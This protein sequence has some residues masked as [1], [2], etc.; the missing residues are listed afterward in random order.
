MADT[1]PKCGAKVRYG[2]AGTRTHRADSADCLRNQLATE[3]RRLTEAYQVID[4]FRNQ[5]AQAQAIIG[6]LHP[7]DRG[8]ITRETVL[9]Y[10]DKLRALEEADPMSGAVATSVLWRTV[11]DF[12]DAREAAEAAQKAKPCPTPTPTTPA[13]TDPSPTPESK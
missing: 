2:F 6:R 13:T 1:C 11:K 3:H 7:E 5:L 4:D 10:L 8:Y 12:Y 9:G